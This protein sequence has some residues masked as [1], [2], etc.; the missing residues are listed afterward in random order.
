M[1][2]YVLPV[3]GAIVGAWFG[4]PQL[5][6]AIGSA[7]GNAV[8]PQVI[9]GP[10]LGELAQQTG[11]EG[12]PRPI[13]FGTS[14]PIAGNIIVKGEPVI[15]KKK[16]GGGLFGPKV[17]SEYVYRTYAIGICEGP[18]VGIARVWRNGVL[19]YDATPNSALNAVDSTT[20]A[21]LERFGFTARSN[22]DAFLAQT[23]F[24]LGDY[25]QNP[26]PHLE[27]LYGV[28]TTP[29]HRGTAYMVRIN[30]DLTDLRG[31]IPQWTFQVVRAGKV[32]E[33]VDLVP[34]ELSRFVNAHFPLQDSLE[35]YEFTGTIGINTPGGLSV[36]YSGTSLQDVIDYFT[37]DD[38]STF[39]VSASGGRAPIHYLGYSYRAG[40]VIPGTGLDIS[41]AGVSNVIPQESVTD[42]VELY[43]VYNDVE[44]DAFKTGTSFSCGDSFTSAIQDRRGR[45][46]KRFPS[47][48]GGQWVLSATCGGGGS[49]IYSLYPLVIR[50]R[51]KIKPPPAEEGVSYEEVSGTFR[52]L[53]HGR[54]HSVSGVSKYK[55][56]KP[57]QGP[58]LPDTDPNYNSSSFWTA[59]YNAAVSAGDMPPGWTYN[60]GLSLDT[61]PVATTVAY[62]RTRIEISSETV[63]LADVIS[64]LCE[65]CGLDETKIDVSQLDQEVRGFVVTNAYPCVSAL[66]A[67]SE[68]FFFDPSNYDGVVHFIPRGG[69]P[70]A[71]ITEDD[72]VD[73]DEDIDHVKRSDPISIPRVLH[74]S[75]HDINGGLAP[76]KQ[77]SERSGDRRSIGEQ[78]LQTAVILNADE[79]ARVIDINHKVMIEAQRGELKFKL[80]DNWLRLVCADPII[81]Q[82]QGRSERAMIQRVDTMDGYQEY[83]AIRDRQSAYTSD[84]EGI[85][86]APQTPP[87]S[88]FV[89]PTLIEVIDS[90]ILRDAD[91]GLGLS[92]Y[93]AV[94][95]V[96][97][98]WQGALIELSI[99]GG[100]NYI[101]SATI[102][103]SAIIGETDSLMASHPHE[104]PDEVNTVRVRVYTPDAELLETDLTGMLNRQNLALIGDEI[105][106]F[107]NA[108]EVEEGVWE[109]SYFLRGRFG[110]DSVAHG[111]GSRFVLLDRTSMAVVPASLADISRTL[112]FRATSL[113]ST[114]STGRVVSIQYAGQSQIEREP[115][116]LSAHIDGTDAVVSWQGVGRIGSGAAVTHGSRFE[117]YRVTFDDGVNDAITVDTA[118]QTVTQD[119]SSLTLPIKIRVQQLN[120]FTGAGPHAEVILS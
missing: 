91:D 21:L 58:I 107:A 86:P 45:V 102:R 77:T 88:S 1:A 96:L 35:Y 64:E 84:V 49:G 53:A 46:A 31:A 13:V 4:N 111:A 90:H 14:P 103:T 104:F 119:I 94:S 25:D 113:G 72:M 98:A 81:L 114:T 120:S 115:A 18:I 106:Q 43:L 57:R 27:E 105:I 5:G 85:P 17:E 2:R 99:D 93:V 37:R 116:Y 60:P 38:Y 63:P 118:E 15:R 42:N 71:T 79:A 61:Y 30:E 11:Q 69:N 44:P 20:K 62:E 68:V 83:L 70:V 34:G 82:W 112:T 67:L 8:D 36:T 24:Y 32:T 110:T 47:A 73:D 7:I 33:I 6:W 65:R 108:D 97:A 117:G 75:Y 78:V 28:G 39:H 41:D 51:R 9:K 100:E 109:L 12:T 56:S 3:A 87:P 29:A 26:S 59:A 16:Q 55:L 22:N 50:V 23:E 10:S 89:G 95:G 80:P 19:V 40:S 66:R 101:D 48:P 52:T 76:D 74:L 92:Y 54:T